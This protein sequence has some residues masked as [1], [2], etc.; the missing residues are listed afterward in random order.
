MD[1]RFD[2]ANA[3]PVRWTRRASVKDA[4]T[5]IRAPYLN[6]YSMSWCFGSDIPK[7]E[8]ERF[9]FR[10]RPESEREFRAET[11][12]QRLDVEVGLPRWNG[13]TSSG[14]GW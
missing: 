13:H 8:S 11:K 6:P 1:A 2:A 3:S 9:Q 14:Y 12:A 10:T 7:I 5:S 4:P